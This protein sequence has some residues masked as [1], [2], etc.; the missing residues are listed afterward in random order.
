MTS[1]SS[2]LGRWRLEDQEF[3][4]FLVYK[5]SSDSGRNTEECV[6]KQTHKHSDCHVLRGASAAR[7]Q[8]T[9]AAS[10]FMHLSLMGRLREVACFVNIYRQITGRK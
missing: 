3:K 9:Y 10:L 8:S 6:L 1:A 5:V 2:A 4:V 7:V